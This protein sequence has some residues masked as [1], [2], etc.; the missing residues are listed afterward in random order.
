MVGSSVRDSV[1]AAMAL[2]DIRPSTRRSYLVAL[3]PFLDLEVGAVNVPDL[4]EV[5]LGI[6]NQNSRRKAVLSLKACLD[7]RAVIALRV[8]EAVPRSYDLLTRR[9]FGWH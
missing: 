9:R 1:T 5:L 8:P 2:K 6:S 4:N 3:K 7:H